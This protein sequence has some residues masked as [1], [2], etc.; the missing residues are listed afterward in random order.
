MLRPIGRALALSFLAALPASAQDVRQLFNEGVELLRRG[1]DEEALK[2]FQDVLAADPTQ[3]AAYQLWKETDQE[4]WL[5]LL[6]KGG[7]FEKIGRRLSDLASLGQKEHKDD[8]AAIAALVD[9][10]KGNSDGR[11]Q[12][13]LKLASEHGAFAVPR[14][15][16]AAG[17]PDEP[18]FQ[19]MAMH[20]LI[21]LSGEAVLPLC[22]ATRSD[23][24]VLRRNVASILGRIGDRRALGCL[25]RLAESDPEASVKKAAGESLASMKAGPG[26]ARDAFLEAGRRALGLEGGG[27]RAIDVSDVVWRWEGGS[28]TKYAVPRA[29]YAFELARGAF[30]DA[31]AVDP[32]CADAVAGIAYA[33]AGQLASLESLRLSGADL[34]SLEGQAARVEEGA[35]PLAAAGPS[36]LDGA[37]QL[38][39]R[40]KEGAVAQALIEAMG[41][42]G[43]PSQAVLEALGD[44][45]KRVRY[46]AAIALG[47]AMPNGGVAGLEAVPGVL[48]A[49]VAEDVARI[50]HLI[51]ENASRR[52]ATVQALEKAGF[53]VVASEGGASGLA[54]VRRFPGVDLIVLSASLANGKGDFST[55]NMVIH[56]LKE[57]FRTAKTPILVLADA[58]KAERAKELFGSK[59]QQVVSA[60]DAPTAKEASAG[61]MNADRERANSFA[62]AAAHV[63]AHLSPANYDLAGAAGTVAAGLPTKMKEVVLPALHFLGA[64]GGGESVGACSTV[65]AD[66]QRTPEERVAS[67]HALGRLFSRGVADPG[68]VDKLKAALKDPDLGVRTAAAGALGRANLT[69]G[70]RA[71]ILVETRADLKAG[72]AK[73]AGEG[74]GEMKVPGGTR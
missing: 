72:E 18:E 17:N 58:A 31:L 53:F 71:A 40:E 64:A 15:L 70:D 41:S 26:S 63:L 67:A 73:P 4:L 49:A 7:E 3:D 51:D 27:M 24:A 39:R 6:V 48:A 13:V 68:A 56:D 21:Q 42:A 54:R 74:A 61:G 37:L 44:E 23:S 28:L 35:V 34:S 47:G 29:F 57:D 45:D 32:S 9:Q 43:A 38:A 22:E 8:P 33:Y 59:V 11:R 19:V 12:A 69:G 50:V 25:R 60:V 14:L 2:K 16:Q 20:A 30:H 66:P 62:K 46:A 10:L 36:N 65:L 1:K 55:T 5:K 52:K